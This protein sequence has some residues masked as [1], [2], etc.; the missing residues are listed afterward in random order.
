MGQTVGRM[1]DTWE[2]LIEEENRVLHWSSEVL[3]KVQDNVTNEDTF[4]I[5]YDDDKI[6]T[7]IDAWIQTNQLRIDKAINKFPNASDQLKDTV[8][9]EINKVIIFFSF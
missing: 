9:N 2:E 5:D 4:L 8:R 3:A 1:P 6:N 7:K